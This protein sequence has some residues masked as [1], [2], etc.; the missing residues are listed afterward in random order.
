MDQ[1]CDF[2]MV[3][4][5]FLLIELSFDLRSRSVLPYRG[6][7]N[8]FESAGQKNL[9]LWSLSKGAGQISLT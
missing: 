9:R 7:G 8:I 4:I 3:R 6:S 5:R 1:L 2:W